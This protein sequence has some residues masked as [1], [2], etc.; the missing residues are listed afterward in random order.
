[1]DPAAPPFLPT[2]FLP[3]VNRNWLARSTS[4]SVADNLGKTIRDPPRDS[5]IS[6]L[7]DNDLIRECTKT[8]LERAL[9]HFGSAK[10][11]QGLQQ[12]L[13]FA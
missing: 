1:M 3:G 4:V 5:S 6:P 8:A 13:R 9:P 7:P 11:D 10:R 2:L 12:L